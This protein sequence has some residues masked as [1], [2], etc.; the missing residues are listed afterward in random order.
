M[1]YIYLYEK[2]GDSYSRTPTPTPPPPF[3]RKILVTR[4]LRPAIL[5]QVEL[6]LLL[7]KILSLLHAF[8]ILHVN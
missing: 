6:E 4:L 7:L 5:S 1:K 2:S 8:T 3:P